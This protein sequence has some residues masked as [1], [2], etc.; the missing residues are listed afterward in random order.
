[1]TGRFFLDEWTVW[2]ACKI[3]LVNL[4]TDISA[5][6]WETWSYRGCKQ[7]SLFPFAVS[8]LQTATGNAIGMPERKWVPS[9]GEFGGP[10]AKTLKHSS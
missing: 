2:P 7:T 4:V 8:L 6:S 1:M 3:L 5:A 9:G 10:V